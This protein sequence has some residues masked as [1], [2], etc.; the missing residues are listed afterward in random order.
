MIRG[1]ARS[2][3]LSWLAPPDA[4]RDAFGIF[5]DFAQARAAFPPPTHPGRRSRPA[6]ERQVATARGGGDHVFRWLSEA[7]ADGTRSVLEIGGPDGRDYRGSLGFRESLTWFVHDVH[8]PE[9]ARER[10]PGDGARHPSYRPTLDLREIEAEL[11][12]CSGAVNFM[13]HGRPEALLRTATHRPRHLILDEVPL[14][15]GEDFVC[16]RN[17]GDGFFAPQYVYNRRRLVAE[18]EREGYA[19]VGAWTANGRG[20]HLRGHPER[21]LK[22]HSGLYFRARP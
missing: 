11:W 20:L 22:H 10:A 5:A 12:L 21:S 15:D 6:G 7:L 17:L 3:L 18:T 16:A 8:S 14:Y 19:L 1:W 9:G 4:P 13:A 2:R